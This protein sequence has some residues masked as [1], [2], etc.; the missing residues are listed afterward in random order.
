[1]AEDYAQFGTMLVNG[2]EWNGKR[3]LSPRTIELMASN[4]TGE[5]AGGQWGC[6]RKA[7]ALAWA[8]RSLMIPWPLIAGSPAPGVGPAPTAPTCTSAGSR[9]G[10][11][12]PD[13]DQHAGT[14]ARLRERGRSVDCE[15]GCKSVKGSTPAHCWEGHMKAG[16]GV[17]LSA[18]VLVTASSV[19]AHHPFAAQYDANKPVIAG[20]SPRS[21]GRITRA[22]MSM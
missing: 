6:H 15:V 7:S 18:L 8:S 4:H 20:T 9:H 3:Y 12:H 1:M 2:G 19:Q 17:L 5:M 10:A 22:S 13:A 16:I 14:A 11:D 21:S